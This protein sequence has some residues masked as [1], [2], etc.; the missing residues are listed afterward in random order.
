MNTKYYISFGGAAYHELATIMTC[1]LQFASIYAELAQK[2][3][4][5]T[6]VIAHMAPWNHASTDTD[7]LQIYKRW[8]ATGDEHLGLLLRKAGIINDESHH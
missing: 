7:L 8:L 3:A 5:L 2:F 1:D 6:E 4:E